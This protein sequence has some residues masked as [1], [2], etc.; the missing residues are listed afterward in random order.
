MSAI[1]G[2]FWRPWQRA[3]ANACTTAVA[4]RGR[5]SG[6]GRDGTVPGGCTAARTGAVGALARCD[7]A[8]A[9]GPRGT[10]VV[11]RNDG[12]VDESAR[13]AIKQQQQLVVIDAGRANATGWHSA[14]TGNVENAL[15]LS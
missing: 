9:A 13:G 12:A 6:L 8:C 11:G 15:E 5:C 2:R 3:A 4:S 10:R 14:P 7:A 1:L